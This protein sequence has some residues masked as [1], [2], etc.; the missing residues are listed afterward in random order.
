[1]VTSGN[2]AEGSKEITMAKHMFH[3]TAFDP[4]RNRLHHAAYAATER[5]ARSHVD[6]LFQAE[7]RWFIVELRH[8]PEPGRLSEE[9][10]VIYSR[11]FGD[12][13]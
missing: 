13:Q 1:M 4:F 2:P 10:P 9:M 5:A 12:C 7:R 3:I 6:Q 8:L 11:E